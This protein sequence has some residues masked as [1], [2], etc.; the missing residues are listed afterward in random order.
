MN[1]GENAA[2]VAAIRYAGYEKVCTE[3]ALQH[4]VN[5]SQAFVMFDFDDLLN[6]EE[7]VE[8]IQAAK[9]IRGLT[10]T[11]GA[12]ELGEMRTFVFS[13]EEK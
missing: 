10:D 4:T 12:L 13:N 8:S 2:R 5:K 1:I 11:A 3:F 7:V 9:H 6:N